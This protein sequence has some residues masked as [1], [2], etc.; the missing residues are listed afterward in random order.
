MRK[1][2]FL[3][4]LSFFIISVSIFAL[5]KIDTKKEHTKTR[6][7]SI[8]N[9]DNA[10]PP[11]ATISGT[12]QVCKDEN[13]APKITFTGSGGDAPYT[14]TYNINGGDDQTIS[15]SENNASVSITVNTSIA[16][17]FTY[18]LISVEDDK[19]D[20]ENVSGNATIT[21]INSPDGSLGGTGSGTTFEGRPVFKQCSNTT[22][23]FTFTNTSTTPSSL[24][25]N[26]SI[27]WGDGTTNFIQSNWSTTTHSYAVGIYNLIYTIEGSNGCNTTTNYTVFVGSNP[28][29][30]LGNP[31]N[32]D[33][34]NSRSL[35]FPITGTEN[36]PP[37][38]TYTVTFN[39]GSTP[40]VFNHPPPSDIT[41]TFS[42]SS[43][44][45]TSS[46]GSNSYENS[47]SANIVASNPCSSSSVGVVPIYVSISPEA[48]F[49]SP[50]TSCTNTNTCFSNMSIGEENLGSGSVCD[51]SPN[52]IWEVLPNSGYNIS[53]GSLGNDFGLADGNSWLSG[54]DDLCLNFTTAG[55]YTVTLK[56]GNR[57]GSDSITKT[58]CIEPELIPTFTLDTNSGCAPLAVQTTNTTDLTDSCGGETHLWQ[59]TYISNFCGTSPETWSFTNSTDE[60]SA[61]PSINFVTAGTYTVTLITT[62]SCGTNS[63]SQTIEVKQ[64]PTATINAIPDTCGSVSIN[65]VATIASCAPNSET[66]TYSWSFPGGNPATATTLDPGTITYATPGSYQVSFSITNSC[67]TATDTEDF[68]VNPIPNITNT[69]LTQTICSGTDTAE[70]ILTSDITNTTYSWTATA[71]S[72]VTGFDASGNTDTIPVQTIFNSNTTSEDVTYTITP[73]VG[74]CDGTS[75]NLIITVDPAPSFTSQPQPETICVNGAITPLSVTVNGPGTPSYQWYSNIVDDNSTGTL[76]TNETASTYIPPNTPVGVTFYYCIVSFTSGVGCNEITTNTARIEIVDGIQIDTNPIPSQTICNGGDIPSV[77]SVTHSGGT[78]IMSYQ[79]YSNTTNTYTGGTAITGANNID[80]TPPTFNTSGSYYYY[81]VISPNGSGCVD[82]ISDVAEI[83]VVDDPTITTQPLTTQTLCQ[84]IT[85]QDL[86]V[87]ASGGLGTIY[88]YQWYSNS[89]N[90]NS[91]G[92]LIPNETN[93]IFT[94]PTIAIGTLYYYVEITQ[95]GAGCS[96]IS[97][98]SKVNINAAPSFTMQ[99]ISETI[100]LGETFNTLSVSY[101]NGV[102]TPKYQWYSNAVNDNFTGTAIT[103]AVNTNYTP[104]SG[105]VG[106]VYYY[107]VIT[108]SSGGCTEITS[109]VAENT[110][111]QTPNIS[112]KTETI[113]SGI[114]FDIPP[115]ASNGDVAPAGTTYILTNPVIN[116]SGTITG[117]SSETTPQTSISQTLTNTTTNPATV[118]YTVTPV[119]GICT[120]TDFSITIT[121]NPSISVIENITHSS[122]YLSNTGSIEISIT[123]GVPFTTGNPYQ[124]SWTRPNGYTN[125]NEDISNLEPGNYEITI[126]DDGGC[127]YKNTFTI[128]EPDE[129]VFSNIDFDPETISCFGAN[130]GSIGIDISGGTMPY[131]YNWTLNGNPYN[132]SEDLTNLAPGDYEV[133][134]I[135]ANNC[136]P[137]VKSFEIIEPLLLDTSL[138]NQT[139][140]ICFG[141]AT[142]EININTVGGRPIEINPGVFDYSYSWTG[143]NG[144]TSSLQNLSG[145]IA[146]TY[147]L[148]VTDK[149]N[150]T[151]TLEVV[152]NQTDEI[153]IDYTSTEIECYGD[154]NASITINSITGG[155][156]SYA[157]AWSN[158]GSGMI[159]NNLSAGTYIITVTDDTN[160]EKQAV[161][162]IDEA[163]L[164]RITPD[165]TQVSCFGENDARII[166][167]L[168][169][170]ID[171][172]NLVWDDDATA[173]IE[174]NNISPGIYTVTITDGTP[175]EITETFTITEP[176]ALS[177]SANT[178]DALDCEDANSGAINLIV[179]GG[180]LPHSYSWS[181]GDT[182]EDLTNIPP[183]DYSVT[184]TDANNCKI[185]ESWTIN[186]FEP[187]TA[188]VETVT[189]F[190]CET[191]YVNQTFEAKI[192]GGVP[193]YQLSWSSG[194][195][196][197]N[198][199]QF[200]NTTQNG[201]VILDVVDSYGCSTNYSLNVNVPVLGDA[202]FNINASIFNTYGFYSKSDPIQ[203]INTSIGDYI[204]ISWDF[205]D[206]NFSSEESPIHTYVSEGNYVVTQTVTYPFGCIY[207]HDITLNIEK[208]YSLITPNAFTPNNDG[209]NDYFV[210]ESIALSNMTL[211]IY[212]TWGSLIYSETGE[213]LKGWDG[214]T[215]GTNAE[216]GNYY[217]TLTAKTFYGETITKEGAFVSIK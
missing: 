104:P 13:P 46:D 214:T 112:T 168:E 189:E 215:N 123:G 184:I 206:G 25:T 10:P 50:D 56:T 1:V 172:I 67:G 143:P 165:I 99:P 41:H 202:T 169:G 201:L 3:T 167:N 122:C 2:S 62:N 81:V 129:L 92:T 197:G 193:P 173:G 89:T 74:G 211:N 102:G 86:E 127:P 61:S 163:P 161:I 192:S 69:N 15:T 146:G 96:I 115:N 177:L 45:T 174:R 217:F 200:M 65:P 97:N 147:N 210:P 199:N 185:S 55:T 44:N 207:T 209:L 118:S 182:T 79:W 124:I 85:P 216:N 38:T 160:C 68:I 170:G 113:C 138:I 117:A 24:N 9:L 70:V 203:F 16:D 159:Q 107:A 35:T 213:N 88:N 175:C 142:G 73:S 32:T 194:T 158:L 72:G 57:C 22:S 151:D 125:S 36:N 145:L 63:V 77:L 183:G 116:P 21:I 83:I 40:Q 58:I 120:G 91:G 78:G 150:C 128:T 186:R 100:C 90:T 154:N 87:I 103:G 60:N 157:I 156:P 47:F 76:I 164:F 144:F 28:A 178:I 208:G 31:G 205:G 131:T 27:N 121:V 23:T 155:N 108:F 7:Y 80:Y 39:D 126:T 11:T 195:I 49:S 212:N 4:I 196:S 109:Q 34:C 179:T 66:L 37:G 153:I 176:D 166:L 20:I 53:Q 54:S 5:N 93:N 8:L 139:D 51:T 29:V 137:I 64:P 188:N 140:I 119:S 52:I 133:T 82:V 187:L 134:V 148:I 98:T 171:P 94:P 110:V 26:Y 198:N 135:D 84:G 12:T 95:P 141:D 106:T 14:F 42:S 17:I 6:S 111:N 48:E 18:N 162:V 149:S 59:V 105:T 180:T 75:V 130:N 152:L 19:N 43:C 190:D 71:P 30:S 204:S 181:N 101:S 136:S 114:T 132:K 191:R 33:I